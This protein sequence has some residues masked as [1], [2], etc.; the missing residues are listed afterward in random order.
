MVGNSYLSIGMEPKHDSARPVTS[1]GTSSCLMLL[2]RRQLNPHLVGGI[3]TLKN[4]TVVS[5]GPMTFPTE[6][7]VIIQPCSS[8]HQPDIDHGKAP[9]YS[10]VNPLFLW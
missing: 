7:K 5:W 1:G 8:H 9:F 4:M 3:P 6:W 10:W 2:G